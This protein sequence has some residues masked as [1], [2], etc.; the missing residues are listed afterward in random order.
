MEGF[1][2][3]P[4]ANIIGKSK[5]T[6]SQ[7]LD[8]TLMP[9]PAYNKQ[10]AD[11]IYGE[12]FRKCFEYLT[13]TGIVG[14][15]LEFGTLRGYTA[16]VIANLM[17]EFGYAGRLH[18]FDSFEGLPDIYSPVDQQSY[19][20]AV[21]K[22]WLSGLMACR[23]DIPLRIEKALVKII[24][25]AQLKIIKGYFEDTLESHLP[26]SQAAL[27]HV[28]CDLYAS[29]KFVL[30]KVLASDL[31]QDGCLLLFDDFN[32]NRANPYMG[33]RRALAE[34]FAS[35][36]RFAYSPF[37]SYGWH[38]QVFFVHDLEALQKEM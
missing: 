22:V 14:D 35:Q 38:G 36:E 19:E 6:I 5:S 11:M 25:A 28:D 32:C 30:S 31:L 2:K 37:F 18:L 16:R 3:K 24:P 7:F 27:I 13:G 21:N 33:E 12:A 8:P 26:D 10:R 4:L 9:P 29:A 20:V 15:I 17:K 1:L 34:I 23:K